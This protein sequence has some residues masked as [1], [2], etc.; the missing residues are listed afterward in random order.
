M[1]LRACAKYDFKQ[2]NND[3]I[4]SDNGR[5]K[6][7]TGF[8]LV[9]VMIAIV[10]FSIG[11]FAVA[12]MQT[13]AVNTNAG[14]FNITEATNFAETK[15][16]EL[17]VLSFTDPDLDDTD[18]DGDATVEDANNDGV[19]DDGGNFGLDDTGIPGGPSGADQQLIM[20]N[21]YTV[22]WNIADGVPGTNTKT[23]NVIVTWNGPGALNQVDI[24]SVKS[25]M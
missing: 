16:E 2:G 13:K 19:D 12:T 15:M 22:S 3:M 23:I 9:E 6:K 8:T 14:A 4:L 5:K 11:L 25:P 21:G 1:I 10:V 18:V 17:M 7:E 24:V 20:L